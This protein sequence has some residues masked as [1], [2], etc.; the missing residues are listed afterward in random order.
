MYGLAEIRAINQTALE[1][2]AE[3]KREADI[4]ALAVKALNGDVA[5]RAAL[6]KRQGER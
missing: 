3:R 6:L 2:A 5:A 4:K 1:R